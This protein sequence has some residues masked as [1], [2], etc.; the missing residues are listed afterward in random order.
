MLK[1]LMEST[2]K[3]GSSKT[4]IGSGVT[5]RNTLFGGA[6]TGGM[7]EMMMVNSVTTLKKVENGMLPH[8]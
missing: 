8:H 4:V 1:V 7:L 2:G 3:P 5:Q 6:K